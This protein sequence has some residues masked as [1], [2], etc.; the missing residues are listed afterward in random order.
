VVG[1]GRYRLLAQF[2][3]DDRVNAQ[4]WRARD[5]QLRRDVALTMLVGES[6]QAAAAHAAR[7]TLER[8]AH[9]AR[10]SHPGMARVLDV[11]SLGNGINADE[12]LLGIVVADWSQGTDLID[13]I[14]DHP[15]PGATAARL[16][17]PLASAVELAHQSGLVLGV[18]HP[19]RI[20]VIP[21]GGLRLAFP[22]PLPE[23][24]LHDDVRGLGAILY[25]LL[26]GAWA[27]PGGPEGL[28]R[29]AIGPNGLVIPP[30]ALRLNVPEELSVAAV[31]SLD[32]STAAGI[33]TST[34]LIGVLDRI[35]DAD[36]PTEFL[37]PAG[38]LGTGLAGAE[39]DTT[40][41]TTAPPVQDKSRKRKLL[42]GVSVLGVATLAV[43]I[44]IGSLL[45]GFFSD[46]T[47]TA[48][49]PTVEATQTPGQ[50][51]APPNA[52]KPVP[53]GPIKPAGVVEY[54]IKG[55][56]D[57]PK[58]ANNSVDGNQ[59]T[60]WKTS[61]Y[62]QQFPTFKPG[63]GLIASFAEP[64]KFATVAIDS[65]SEG[66]VVQIRSAPSD[67]PDLDETKVIGE[68]TLGAG[69]TEI[70]LANAEPTQFVVIWITKLGNG[71]VS[72][73]DEAS[74]VRAQ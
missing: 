72:Q 43:L 62:K 48:T 68:A 64:V 27:L 61:V 6:S 2:G 41:W 54:N 52:S 53:S 50:T 44:W 73:I 47:S 35:V 3:V 17:E 33:R 10:L 42:V 8:A 59:K 28:P 51:G 60:S 21:D 4:L 13:L 69:H 30:S 23:A 49:G 20:R 55:D 29:A 36:E 63:I 57:N 5:G 7:R 1:D 34:T 65:P 24:T 9:A 22:A 39:D 74:F 70:S 26:T 56:P 16:L 19:Q 31:R 12:G 18:D 25:L 71:N 66:T 14:S 67:K 15:L 37:G 58:R 46:D 40:V 32:D 38:S 11:L 45:I